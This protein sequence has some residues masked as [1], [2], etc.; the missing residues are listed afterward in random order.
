MRKLVFIVLALLFSLVNYSQSPEKFTYQSIVRASDGTVLKSAPLGIK[1]SVIQGTKN[2]ISVYSETHST[3][4]NNNGL[5]TLIIGDGTS[6]DNFTDIDW[7]TGQYFLK[8]EVDPAGGINYSIE[9][10]SQLLSVPYALYATRATG[11]DLTKDAKGVLPVA[12]GGTGSSTSPMI[13]VVTAPNASVARQLLGTTPVSLGG[14]GSTTSPM[15]GVVTAVDAAAARAVLGVDKAGSVKPNKLGIK[16]IQN[17]YL[18]ITDVVSTTNQDPITQ[19]L[20]A[21]IVPTTLGGTGA[22]KV[23]MIGAIL[24][25]DSAASRDS[26]GLGKIAVQDND[27]IDIDGGAID[28]TVIGA[29]S[30]ST[31][32]FNSVS[33]GLYQSVGATDVIIKTGNTTT[34]NITLHN[35]ADGN[36]HIAPDGSGQVILDDLTFPAA[37]GTAGQVLKTDGSGN[38][39]WI[40]VDAAGKDNSTAVT[41]AAVTDNYLTLSGQEIT[42][43]IVPITLGG[44]GSSTAPMVGVVTAADAAAARDSLALGT[45]AIQNKDAVD[46]DGGAI[47]GTVIG[48]NASSTGT[49]N[50]VSSGIFQSIGDTDVII[51]TGNTTTGDITIADGADGNINITPNGTGN[52]VIPRLKLDTT[53]ITATGA[54]I[55]IIDGNTSATSTTVVAGDQI[56]LN[57]DG[58]MKQ[59]ALPDVATYLQTVFDIDGL[60]D[61]KKAGTNFTGSMLIGNET[62]GTLDDNNAAEYNLGVGET[63]LDALTTGDNNVALGYDALKANTTGGKNLAIGKGALDAADTESNNIA[64]GYDALGGAVA[65][66]EYNV[67]IGNYALDAAVGG[68]TNEGDYNV[69][70]GDNTLSANTTGSYNTATGAWALNANTTGKSNTGIGLEALTKNTTGDYNTGIGEG[71]LYTN[72]SGDGNTAIGEA[73][74]KVSTGNYNTAVGAESLEANTG[75]SN[76]AVGTEAGEATTTGG[77]NVFVG[78]D[79]GDANTTGQQNII[80]GSGSDA[81]AVNAENQIVI[82]YG[83]VGQGDNIAIIGN[84]SV[85]KVY[86]S[87]DK[88]ASIYAKDLV[89]E[90]DETITNA[91]DGTVAITATNTTVSGNLSGSGNI[92][93]FD[94]NLNDQT[95]TT[96]TLVASDNGKVVALNNGS[97]IALTI[98]AGLGDGFNCLIVQKGAGQVTISAGGGV[99][100]AN[101]SSETKTAGQYAI[102]SIINIGSEAYIISGDTGS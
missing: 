43:G 29:N 23:P 98:N 75:T 59:V 6:S 61:A 50:S 63:A 40:A 56:I 11:I 80:I 76:T 17:N 54:E 96:Y 85:T 42:S 25:A 73:A 91:S 83:A 24:A 81:S 77:N 47:D 62:P 21:G 13:G 79:A 65:G 84:T 70:V 1:L 44:T 8:V 71:A 92:S 36:I 88:G 66:G 34:G 12:L 90:N 27:A 37:D 95:G 46:I 14:T 2:G 68:G 58:T 100:I 102:V 9:Q 87:Q 7:S 67:A 3:S 97:A 35:G 31:G 55:N 52:V 78:A 20:S 32:T 38:L 22:T 94:A 48:A 72:V 86:A 99:T 69:A 101:R 41:L 19:E 82:G 33:S 15:I 53:V 49:F 10:T 39:S 28:G 74:L 18:S 4:T 30:S 45:I 16:P 89:L 26:L 64:I 51:K 5:V 60:T 93:G 57:D